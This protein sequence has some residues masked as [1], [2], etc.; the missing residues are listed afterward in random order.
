MPWL[1]LQFLWASTFVSTLQR[2][3]SYQIMSHLHQ[4]SCNGYTLLWQKPKS[5]TYSCM[6]WTQSPPQGPLKVLPCPLHWARC[7]ESY[8]HYLAEHSK[9]PPTHARV[10]HR[11]C[12][13]PFCTLFF[14]MHNGTNKYIFEILGSIS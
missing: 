13:K 14:L 2:N 6:T 11:L 8:V 9:I 1:L 12:T 3:Q 5:P 7:Q 10:L 4:K